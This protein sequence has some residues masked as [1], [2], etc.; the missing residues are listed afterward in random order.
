MPL[1]HQQCIDIKTILFDSLKKKFQTYKPEPSSMPFHVRLLG[2]DRMAL[3]SFIHSLNTNFGA[4]IFEPVAKAV[5]ASN[6]TKV[7]LNQNAGYRI[8]TKAHE[9]IQSIMDNLSTAASLPNKLNEIN[10][11]REAA[12][13]GSIKN[14]KLTKVDI[15][16]ESKCGEIYLIDIKA[17]KPN[18]GEFKGFKR[19]LLEWVAATLVEDSEVQINTLIAI[20]YNP[21]EPQPYARW[22]MR[23]MLDLNEELKVAEEFWNFLGGTGTY[24]QLLDIFEQT[25]IELRPEI[26]NYFS[27][28]TKSF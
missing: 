19:T 15:K 16:L 24:N 22:T 26:D 1:T 14:V 27:K 4:S 9:T 7:W 5:A 17:A 8:S 20:P 23:G 2:R 28:N 18:A 25:G 21:Y 13:K 11:I 3:F 10:L 6:F 12:Q